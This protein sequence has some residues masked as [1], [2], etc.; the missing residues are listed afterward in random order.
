MAAEQVLKL[1][2]SYWFETTIFTNKTPL[3]SHHPTVDDPI[4]QTKVVEVL[5]LDTKLPLVPTLDVRSYSDQNLDSTE[6]VWS[7]SLSPHSVLTMQKLRTEF[8]VVS[9]RTDEKEDINTKKKLRHSHRRRRRLRLSKGKAS[10]SL[11]ELEFMELKGFMDLGFVF[12]EEDKDSR[13]VSLIPG[14]QRLG[15]EDAEEEG[16]EEQHNIDDE[17]VISNQPYLSEAWGV[18]DQ[19]E[20][21]NPLLNWRIPIQ[22]NEIDMKHNLKFWAH[23]VASYVR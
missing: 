14:L 8:S 22:G 12:S 2:D 7:H 4:S 18:F 13:L 21:R 17:T 11:S 9:S 15:R 6:N 5:P 10:M 23:T 19:R 20:V 16:D 1:L 3:K